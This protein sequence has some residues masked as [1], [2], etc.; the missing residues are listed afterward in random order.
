[1]NW[2]SWS[3][4]TQWWIWARLDLHSS[5]VPHP[6][7]SYCIGHDTN[8]IDS[9]F[10]KID[11]IF[12]TIEHD[13]TF[14]CSTFCPCECIEWVTICLIFSI[15]HL[16]EYGE[17]SLSHNNIEL[18]SLDLIITIYDLVSFW[19]EI[20]HCDLF[21]IVSDGAIWWMVIGGHREDMKRSRK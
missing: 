21:S 15:F 18:S 13:R 4:S 10:F 5:H 17:F 6:M 7:S 1:M 20:F 19:F 14:H 3:E 11:F 8:K 16:D 9:D 2:H 12:V